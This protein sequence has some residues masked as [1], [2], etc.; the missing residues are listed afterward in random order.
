MNG[1]IFLSDKVRQRRGIEENPPGV[2][3]HAFKLR[4]NTSQFGPQPI[5]SFRNLHLN[6]MAHILHSATDFKEEVVGLGCPVS[7][8]LAVLNCLVLEMLRDR[9][10]DWSGRKVRDLPSPF[11]ADSTE[12]LNLDHHIDHLLST[13]AEG[14]LHFDQ[15]CILI[16]PGFREANGRNVVTKKAEIEPVPLHDR[17][18]HI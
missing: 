5:A 2:S 16:V 9:Y 6:F 13:I 12:L 11:L 4:I 17:S 3:F 14:S 8:L 15:R 10:L 18:L 1:K 7:G